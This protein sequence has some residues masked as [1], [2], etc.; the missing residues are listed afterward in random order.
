MVNGFTFGLYRIRSVSGPYLVRIK[1]ILSLTANYLSV[2]PE[3]VK[4]VFQFCLKL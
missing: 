4:L 3:M 2:T 1:S